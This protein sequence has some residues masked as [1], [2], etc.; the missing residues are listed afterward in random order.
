MTLWGGRF[1]GESDAI[2]R[3]FNDSFSFDRRLYRCDIKGS[4][5]Y[6]AA[7]QRAGVISSD[8]KNL[9]IDG[10]QQVQ[11]EFEKETFL[12]ASGDEDIHTAVERRLAELIGPVAEKLH[13]GRSRNDQVATDLRLYLL[14][15][16]AVIG[17][18]LNDLLKAIVEKAE[19]E[20]AVV[21]PGYTHMQRAQPILFSHWIM[22]YFWKLGRD[23]K[24]L[25]AVA[26]ATSILPLG[27][28]AL[29]GN[30]YGIDRQWLAS[31]LGF[32]SESENSIDAVNDRDYVLEFL[33][34]A[35]LVQVHLSQMAEEF[36]IWSSHEFGFVELDDAFSTGSSLMPQKKNPDVLEL[37]R[38]KTGRMA[39]H[40]VSLLM[41][42]KGLP[43]AY[44]KDLQEDKEGLFDAIDTLKLELSVVPGLIRTLRLDKEKILRSLDDGMLATDLADYLVQK[45]VSFRRSHELVGEVVKRAEQ[46]GHSLKSL[47]LNEYKQI[48]QAFCQD[49]YSV[50]DFEHSIE[51]HSVRGGTATSSV[52]AQ[53]EKAKFLLQE[54]AEC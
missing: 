46:L 43:S 21:M 20:I 36:I 42:L 28:G 18:K 39:G 4:I 51:S 12:Q 24:R 8:E 38:G 31:E 23:L 9:L 2:M 47:S 14:D 34:C 27:S 3:Q 15:E 29:A 41:I 30:A 45:G 25:F 1:S 54:S 22:S 7:L 49:L 19:Q 33:A 50:Y 10:L 11:D 44:N 6:A 40:L 53:I 26:D 5:A 32:S 48:D 37:M 52:L 13:T 35:A 16:I 17:S